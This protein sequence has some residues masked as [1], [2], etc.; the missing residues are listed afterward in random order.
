MFYEKKITNT[1]LTSIFPTQTVQTDPTV[2][3]K[4]R[5][6]P[7]ILKKLIRFLPVFCFHNPN[8]PSKIMNLF[9]KLFS[10]KKETKA[11]I[12]ED[13]TGRIEN[14]ILQT[15]LVKFIGLLMITLKTIREFKWRSKFRNIKM[16]TPSQIIFINDVAHVI[17]NKETSHKFH[18]MRS[19][20]L[21]LKLIALKKR[22]RPFLAF[23]SKL[24]FS[25]S[26]NFHLF[27]PKKIRNHKRNNWQTGEIHSCYK[28]R[29]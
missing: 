17:E 12:I 19:K 13:Q 1:E 25:N 27:S 20:F 9:T 24:T 8:H 5:T 23:L 4:K 10:L 6:K 11:S 2:S 7:S 29:P 16:A 28:A 3:F 26:L 15:K 14:A 22:L 18:L 21:R